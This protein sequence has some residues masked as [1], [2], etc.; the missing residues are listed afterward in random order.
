MRTFRVL[1]RGLA[2]V[3]VLCGFFGT[4]VVGTELSSAASGWKIV[5]SPGVPDTTYSALQGISCPATNDCFAVGEGGT[6]LGK[7]SET[8][9]PLIDHWDGSQWWALDAPVRLNENRLLGVSC[10][11]R[12][13]CVAV[14]YDSSLNGD[15]ADA[16]VWN[17]RG[18]SAMAFPNPD[19][20][21]FEL[22]S[23]SCLSSKDCVAV[24]HEYNSTVSTAFAAHFDGKSWKAAVV[25]GVGP[26][27]LLEGV[28]CSSATSCVA[29]GYDFTN[30]IDTT[31]LVTTT[32]QTKWKTD[33]K[34]KIAGQDALLTGVSCVK[35]QSCV[36][37]GYETISSSSSQISGDELVETGKGSSWKETTRATSLSKGFDV[38]EGVACSSP[39]ACSVS[40]IAISRAGG[41][42]TILALVQ[43]WN[44]HSIGS[45]AS[46]TARGWTYQELIGA[47]CSGSECF[48][49]GLLSN[50]AGSVEQPLIERS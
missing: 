2:P 10:S 40:G 3:I 1:R 36:A 20:M 15:L 18:W 31:L 11:S 35:A 27:A 47:A 38:P 6:G 4:Q 19:G 7:L 34:V 45:V 16:D 25:T 42:T 5:A 21:S 8:A 39:T 24:G 33:T 9:L 29:V 28:S 43:S 46:Q 22:T 32:T 26:E 49:V 44:G 48:M 23:V 37:V 50:S 13:F 30:D 17:G 12:T 14:G 41:D